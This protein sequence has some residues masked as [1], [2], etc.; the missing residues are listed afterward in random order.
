MHMKQNTIE[1]LAPM[2]YQVIQRHGYIPL[3]SHENNTEGPA[4]GTGTIKLCWKQN[5]NPVGTFEFRTV[6]IDDA[7]GK[8]IDWSKMSTEFLD[9]KYNAL[10]EIPAGGWYRIDIREVKGLQVINSAQVEPIGIGE[11]FV[12]AGQSYAS[13]CNDKQNTVQD[14]QGRV[15]VYDFYTNQW[16]VAHDRQPCFDNEAWEDFLQTGSI[17]PITMDYLITCIRVPIGMVNAAYGGTATREWLPKEILFSNLTNACKWAEDFR[18]ILWQQGESDVIEA[19]STQKYKE[20][21]RIIKNS[22]AEATKMVRPWILAKSTY[23]P[24]CYNTPEIEG[25][26]RKAIHELCMEEGFIEGPDTDIL[27]GVHRSGTD[28]SAHFSYDGQKAAG[29]LWFSTLWNQIN[30]DD[31]VKYLYGSKK[32]LL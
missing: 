6:L 20:N 28:A 24:T 11:V 12:I 31:A 10:V 4:L 23:H 3:N 26:I 21:M 5:E 9:G 17:W 8:A 29:L 27:G 16:R 19:T 7:F 25:W 13:N 15:T 30:N 14:K 1:I 32:E 22:L 2:P 18:Y